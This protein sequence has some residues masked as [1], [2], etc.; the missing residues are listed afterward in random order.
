MNKYIIYIIFIFIMAA[1]AS[2][3]LLDDCLLYYSFDSSPNLEINTTTVV[4]VSGLGHPG[5]LMNNPTVN[6]TGVSNQGLSCD[7]TD[8]YVNTT[9]G[10]T[11]DIADPFTINFWVNTS[12]LSGKY[13]FGSAVDNGAADRY[14][15]L[16]IQ[17]ESDKLEITVWNK[18]TN[19][20]NIV[21]TDDDFNTLFANAGYNM[22][23]VLMNGSDAST[24]AIYKNAV[25]LSTTVIQ[26]DGLASSV[27][28]QPVY[29]CARNRQA[30]PGYSDMEVDEFSL[31]NR[32]LTGDELLEL[33]SL[34]NPYKL[35]KL[36][37]SNLNP[38]NGSAIG[39]S[40]ELTYILSNVSVLAN[41]SYYINDT[42]IYERNES[43][44]GTFNFTF[45]STVWNV[46]WNTI[47]LI[48]EDVDN[49]TT[50]YKYLYVDSE[51]PEIYYIYPSP[52]NDT[53]ISTSNP[54]NVLINATDDFL[55]EIN[56]TIKNSTGAS[57]YYYK[58]NTTDVP[59][60]LINVN[61]SLDFTSV[62]QEMTISTFA[63]DTA[64]RV[65]NQTIIFYY[66]NVY[67]YKCIDAGNLTTLN[68]T[69]INSSSGLPIQAAIQGSINYTAAGN[70]DQ[71]Y[72]FLT[73]DFNASVCLTPAGG[74]VIS[75][76]I[77]LYTVNGTQYNYFQSDVNLSSTRTDIIL[78]V[79]SDT[80]QVLFNVKDTYGT[81]IKNVYIYVDKYDVG[82]NS[83]VT[84]EILN[85]DNSGNAV[86]N[87]ILNTQYYRFNL[88]YNGLIRLIDGPTIVTDVTKNF[89][90]DILGNDYYDNMD[91]IDNMWY[92]LSFNNAT[93]NYRFQ[94]IDPDT[95]V[96][97]KC[98]KVVRY[99]FTTGTD[100]INESCLFS[101]SGTI[102]LN[103]G[104]DFDNHTY[105]GTAYAVT[106]DGTYFSL[107]SLEISF[108]EI[109]QKFN[110]D[111]DK[112][113][114]F[115]SFIF[116]LG[117]LLIGRWHPIASI[118]L[119][120]FSVLLVK[121]IGLYYISYPIYMVLAVLGATAIWRINRAR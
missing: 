49:I 26:N 58:V 13:L 19:K 92:N 33:F 23:T 32:D 8:D 66:T 43:V 52:T 88:L 87:V 110:K 121:W 6:V 38:I 84:S 47:K 17:I 11:I 101:A 71:N 114:V 91:K 97:K 73:S 48:Y 70:I 7:G 109:Y 25:K 72:S 78:Y 46:G 120:I 36:Q 9:Y 85:T 29:L 79:V 31:W 61:V 82:T 119:A 15:I 42:L 93:K 83:Y 64:G 105:L 67:L 95:Q 74:S 80:T 62:G 35:S 118:L 94:F 44:N 100:L 96:Y 37:F 107:D 5:V 81:N 21:R 106:S 14:N 12:G 103:I 99:N 60:H 90:I 53:I 116:I 76:I 51:D 75:S 41:V 112:S 30:V 63:K 55:Y 27:N 111:N 57:V 59:S 108:A 45:D 86:G 28:L 4:D 77:L 40:T 65:S 39:E 56:F 113:G 54:F 117:I 22:L 20:F 50:Q 34:Q 16:Q 24:W 115:F 18:D 104:S 102:L 2:G 98:L 3:A 68:I 69:V 89:I 1:T 10:E